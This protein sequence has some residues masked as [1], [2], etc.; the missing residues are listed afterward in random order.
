M[1]ESR[2]V[3]WTRS[4]CLLPPRWAPWPPGGSS[5]NKDSS[6]VQNVW[7][8]NSQST[9]NEPSVSSMQETDPSNCPKNAL[10]ST[11][12]FPLNCVFAGVSSR[13]RMS[14][15]SCPKFALVPTSIVSLNCDFTL[16][17]SR[18]WMSKLGEQENH[19]YPD[20]L[21]QDPCTWWLFGSL[22]VRVLWM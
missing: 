19:P 20:R 5:F 1:L 10:L 11:R 4:N 7:K 6:P 13:T 2:T 16:D 17:S 3:D 18:N 9:T 21:T 14:T 22:L 15:D 12:W 8:I